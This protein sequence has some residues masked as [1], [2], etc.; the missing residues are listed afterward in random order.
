MPVSERFDLEPLSIC[1]FTG[2][3]DYFV[4]AS[5]QRRR[6]GQT[7]GT[8]GLEVQD[9]FIVGRCLHRHGRRLFPAQHSIHVAS[10]VP[11]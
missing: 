3:F 9:K 7:E 8:R 4:G 2:S 1:P 11:H 6:Q 5:N 10:R